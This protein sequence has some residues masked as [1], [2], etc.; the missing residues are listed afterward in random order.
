MNT[1]A[2]KAFT[3]AS[4]PSRHDSFS[5][6][7][8]WEVEGGTDPDTCVNGKGGAVVTFEDKFLGEAEKTPSTLVLHSDG[9]FYE[10]SETEKRARKSL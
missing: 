6:A 9:T 4:T 2:P 10:E 5:L 8:V 7:S 1:P 3:V